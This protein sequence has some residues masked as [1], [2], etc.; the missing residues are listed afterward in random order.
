M[1]IAVGNSQTSSNISSSGH[2]FGIM[3]NGKAFKILSSS[4]YNF[5]PLAVVRE[6][7]CNARDAHVLTNNLTE[8]FIVKLPSF[9]NLHF[10]VRDF[11][12][13]LSDADILGLYTTYFQSSKTEDNESIGGLGLG[14]KSPLSY[15]SSF[16]VS[17][18]F[19]GMKRTYLAFQSDGGEPDIYC[20][21]AVESDERSGIEVIVPVAAA[22]INKFRRSAANVYRFFATKPIVYLNNEVMDNDTFY[23]FTLENILHREVEYEPGMVA[24]FYEKKPLSEITDS[25]VW[26]KMG[27]VIYPISIKHIFE[28]GVGDEIDIS[29]FFDS[30]RFGKVVIDCKIGELDINA[31]REGLSYDRSTIARLKAITSMIFSKMIR[32]VNDEI[33]TASHMSVALTKCH[34]Y[35]KFFGDRA[36]SGMFTW[37]NSPVTLTNWAALNTLATRPSNWKSLTD[38]ITDITGTNEV[39]YSTLISRGGQT[40]IKTITPATL[41]RVH[42]DYKK[43]VVWI[44]VDETVSG[45]RGAL[46]DRIRAK[47]GRDVVYTHEIMIL[48]AVELQTGI[49]T[50]QSPSMKVN[51]KSVNL[52]KASIQSKI[53]ANTTFESIIF[54][55]DLPTITSINAS[56]RGTTVGRTKEEVYCVNVA[57]NQ[58]AF[59]VLLASNLNPIE[60]DINPTTKRLYMI[61]TKSKVRFNGYELSISR[62]TSSHQYLYSS[63]STYSGDLIHRWVHWTVDVKCMPVS[64]HILT[65]SQY[66]LVET[67]PNWVSLESQIVDDALRV[68]SKLNPENNLYLGSPTLYDSDVFSAA[69]NGSASFKQAVDQWTLLREKL[70][71]QRVI[72]PEFL[73]VLAI[74]GTTILNNSGHHTSPDAKHPLIERLDE[75]KRHE[76]HLTFSEFVSIGSPLLVCITQRA[77]SHSAGWKEDVARLWDTSQSKIDVNQFIT[78]KLQG[79]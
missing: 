79:Q 30:G 66:K 46:R 36:L 4:L 71:D 43:P 9:D 35:V 78:T 39:R 68:A 24:R 51:T 59:H 47:F 52:H 3:A 41:S 54:V 7:S 34:E 69:S 42:I 29:R 22:D 26:A 48:K 16:Q 77:V 17:S 2:S 27:D 15:S 14:S 11:G 33:K 19:G 74:N 61:G 40:S 20:M 18:Y 1:K 73:S 50:P 31:G 25:P 28:D 45:S 49:K 57:A 32:E 67:N 5:K 70:N 44:I 38:Y 37:N 56:A 10:T 55:S 21:T 63:N 53:D 6:I 60:L 65:E 75:F 58:K 13:G 64:I 72:V 8:P 62:S 12:P 76:H 23:E